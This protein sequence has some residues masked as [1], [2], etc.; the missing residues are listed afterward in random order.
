MM[1]RR[2]NCVE[3]GHRFVSEPQSGAV[4]S[5]R[6][7]NTHLSDVLQRKIR[8]NI[9]YSFEFQLRLVSLSPFRERFGCAQNVLSVYSIETVE[10]DIPSTA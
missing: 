5:V 2:A 1:S 7:W 3:G 9:R 4:N 10:A 6:A 8:S